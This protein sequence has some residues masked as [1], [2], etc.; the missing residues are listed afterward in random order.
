[1]A[2]ILDVTWCETHAPVRAGLDDELALVRGTTLTAEAGGDDNRR[3]CE[4]IH[5]ETKRR[6]SPRKRPSR[7][8]S[9]I[10]TDSVAL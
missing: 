9:T 6:A 5:R 8:A 1:M 3:W 2:E 4:M 10:L 7:P